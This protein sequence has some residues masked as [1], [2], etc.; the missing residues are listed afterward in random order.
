M[1]LSCYIIDDEFHAVEVLTD[2]VEKTPGLQLAGS[3]TDPLLGLD[4]ITNSFPDITFLDLDMPG[5]TGLELARIAGNS[6]A[7][8][9]TTFHRGSGPEAFEIGVADYLL[10]PISYERFLKCIQKIKQ[11][12]QLAASLVASG[13]FSFLVKTDTKGKL[14]RIF[15]PEII[16][17]SSEK[18]Y[19]HIHLEKETIKAYL[20]LTELLE[21]LPAEQFCRVH[22]AFIVNLRCVRTIEPGFARLTN[23]TT[24]DIGPTYR[25]DFLQKLDAELIVSHRQH[26]N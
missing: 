23:H 21:K 7:I 14:F 22:R 26:K 9:L 13:P 18:N 24:V 11:E 10:K 4:A 8:V 5:I 1:T 25:E 19:L 17:I 16:Y 12:K 20:T 15:A 3:A 6:T 2:Y